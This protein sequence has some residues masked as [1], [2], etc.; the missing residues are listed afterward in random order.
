MNTNLAITL[1][2]NER[3]RL[4]LS[5]GRFVLIDTQIYRG[6]RRVKIT[7]PES[8]RVG[9]VPGPATDDGDGPAP[10]PSGD[11]AGMR[12]RTWGA[13]GGEGGTP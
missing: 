9:R 10:D 1:K 8:V 6:H 11:G 13:R 7:A 5:D 4:D 2:R 3:V 12:P